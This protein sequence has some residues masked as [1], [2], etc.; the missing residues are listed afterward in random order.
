MRTL[1]FSSAV[2]LAA[3]VSA[4]VMGRRRAGIAVYVFAL[5]V[6]DPVLVLVLGVVLAT[7]RA[8]NPDDR[9]SLRRIAAVR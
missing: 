9:A 4:H 5:A 1:V 8:R 6:I 2:T 3:V 7:T